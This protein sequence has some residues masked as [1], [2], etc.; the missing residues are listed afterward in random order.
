M[1][2]GVEG[3]GML[4]VECLCPPKLHILKPNSHLDGIRRWGLWEVIRT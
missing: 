1:L 4:S 3:I 2:I